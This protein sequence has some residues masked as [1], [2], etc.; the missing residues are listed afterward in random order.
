MMSPEL[1][2][3]EEDKLPVETKRALEKARHIAYEN[4][5]NIGLID[6]YWGVCLEMGQLLV[7]TTLERK[8]ITAV[9]SEKELTLI[10]QLE[11]KYGNWEKAGS[12]Q[13]PYLTELSQSALTNA[14]KISAEKR[15]NINPPSPSPSDL[16]LG[17]VKLALNR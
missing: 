13:Q 11:K 12:D 6:L 14:I 8:N 3:L 4:I 9:D 17:L 7:Q 1:K 15:P 5:T 16:L 2:Q 10:A